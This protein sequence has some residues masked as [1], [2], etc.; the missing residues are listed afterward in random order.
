MKTES[1]G[2]KS[3]YLTQLLDKQCLYKIYA[4]VSSKYWFS[5]FTVGI[6]HLASAEEISTRQ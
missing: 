3:Y 6:S 1:F 2:I 5:R 4:R